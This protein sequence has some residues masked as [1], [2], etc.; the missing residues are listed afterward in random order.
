MAAIEVTNLVK[1]FKNTKAIDDISFSVGA[2]ECFSLLGPNG[3]GKTTTLNILST[4]LKPTA[5]KALVAGFDV[6][7][8]KNE[9]RQSIG[10]VFQ[11]PALDSKLT[12]KENLEFHAMMYGIKPSIRDERIKSLLQ[13]VELTEK[14]E[15]LVQNY[16]GGMKRRLEIARGLIHRPKVL[17]LDEPTLGLDSQT[18]RLIWDYIKKLNKENDVTI[19]LTTHYMEE[20]DFLCDRI[21]IIDRGKIVVNDSPANLKKLHNTNSLDDVFIKYTGNTIRN[22]EERE[23]IW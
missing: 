8:Q 11:E 4:L 20:A 15:T 14:A 18:R 19:I 17:F 3:A 2:G 16:S 1:Y 10:I 9:V 6:A 22:I 23:K 21:A 13:L 7:K 5:G 12:G